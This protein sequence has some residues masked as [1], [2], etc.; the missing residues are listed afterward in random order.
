MGAAGDRRVIDP[1]DRREETRIVSRPVPCGARRLVA[2]AVVGALALGGCGDACTRASPR[3]GRRDHRS[4]AREVNELADALVHRPSSRRPRRG[5]QR[6]R[7]HP[8]KRASCSSRCRLLMDIEL[9]LQYGES[10]DVQPRTAAGRRDLRPGSTSSI[11]T[12]A[13][14]APRRSSRT[15]SSAGPRRRRRADPGRSAGDRP[16]RPRARHAEALINAGYQKRRARG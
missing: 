11:E 10:E 3:S 5:Q 1:A 7:R 16:R 15:P 6:P 4:P 9:S 2:L 13:G 12:P 8:R 14:E